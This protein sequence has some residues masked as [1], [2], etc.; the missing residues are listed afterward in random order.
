MM[1]VVGT[2][3]LFEVV[4][5]VTRFTACEGE[6]A[7]SPLLRGV[8]SVFVGRRERE[9]EGGRGGRESGRGTS[10]RSM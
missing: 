8:Q 6:A 10:W 3:I 7:F 5:L 1:F 4:G 9:G 2:L